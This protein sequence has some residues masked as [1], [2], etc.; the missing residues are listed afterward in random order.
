MT[1][2]NAL[3]ISKEIYTEWEKLWFGHRFFNHR[4]NLKP[5][6][7]SS[8]CPRA[9]H[10][11]PFL[12]RDDQW[13]LTLAAQRIP[14]T[15]FLTHHHPLSLVLLVLLSLPSGDT[16]AQELMLFGVH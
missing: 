12:P 1:T 13:E 10:Q 15:P 2:V 3:I 6:G 7:V 16:W 11:L 14:R 8:F 9:P 4:P 5:R